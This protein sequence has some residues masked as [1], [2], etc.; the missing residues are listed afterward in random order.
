VRARQ[1]RPPGTTAAAACRRCN[2]HVAA[3]IKTAGF[4]HCRLQWIAG[5]QGALD[6]S[7]QW[8]GAV[9]RPTNV[10]LTT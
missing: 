5:W 2:C 8:T 3:G 6:G 1:H 7:R 9:G 4:Q 10:C